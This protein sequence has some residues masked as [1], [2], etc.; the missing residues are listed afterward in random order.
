VRALPG[1][2][3]V[4]VEQDH[5]VAL[6]RG[7][8]S[9][10]LQRAA[11]EGDDAA[12]GRLEQRAGELLLGGAERGFA[13][14]RED[15]LDRLAELGLE[16]RVGIVRRDAERGGGLACRARLARPHEADEDEGRVQRR[17]HPM[18]SS[19]R[20]TASS[21]SSTWSPPNFSR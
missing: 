3:E 16:Q 12:V 18:R 17:R 8:H 11:P 10:G 21:T 19:Y 5:H 14:A 20:A 7:A 1:R 4:D 9:L 6:E 2:V 13:V 15:R